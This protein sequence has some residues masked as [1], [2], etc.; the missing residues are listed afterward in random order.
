MIWCW[1]PVCARS[2]LQ[3]M[4]AR[5]DDVAVALRRERDAAAE[6]LLLAELEH[7]LE[8]VAPRVAV[9]REVELSGATLREWICL[10]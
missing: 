3:R 6:P 1:I 5:L 9:V 7:L 4:D 2:M 10:M 8:R